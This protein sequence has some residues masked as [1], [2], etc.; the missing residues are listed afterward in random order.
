MRMRQYWEERYKAYGR[1]TVG[2]MGMTPNSFLHS[3]QKAH[4][5]IRREINPLIKGRRVLDFG[6]GYGRMAPVLSEAAAFVYGVDISEQAIDQA[7]LF[8]SAAIYKLYNG[9]EIPF[10][11]GFFGAVF[12]WTVLQHIPGEEIS[13]IAQEIDRVLSQGGILALFENTTPALGNKPH[14]WSRSPADY[15]ALF[16]GFLALTIKPIPGID[17]STESHSLMIFQKRGSQ[18]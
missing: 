18:C 17:G 1:F 12:C 10:G 13:G 14:V 4:T 2:R 8:F 9:A 7:R 15:A 11:D 5:I 6:C 3:T 16:P